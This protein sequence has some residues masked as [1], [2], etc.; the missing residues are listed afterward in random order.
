VLISP[1]CTSGL[2]SRVAEVR[3]GISGWTFP[4]WRGLFYPEGLAQKQELHYASRAL[5]TIEINGTFYSLQKPESFAKWAVDTPD[6]FVFT[7]KAPRFI[8]HIRRL[9]DVGVP[10]AN[11]MASGVLRL[12]HKLGPFLWQLPPNLPFDAARLEAFLSLLPHDTQ[13]AA[14]LAR[15]HDGH[16][17]DA[18]WT[19]ADALRPVRHAIEVRH[20]SF[21]T[22]PFLDLLRAHDIA[23]VCVDTDEWPSLMDLTSDFAYCRLRN[24]AETEPPGYTE[25]QIDRWAERALAWSTGR[26]M[27]DG[28]F[29]DQASQPAARERDVFAYFEHVMKEHA[30]Q[31]AQRLMRRVLDRAGE[32][33]HPATGR[34]AA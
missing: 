10:V 8:T 12:G 11:F 14:A 6:D 15:G 22:K 26:P 32:P 19:E 25:A 29:V 17:K 16:L 30:P 5:R 24:P 20:E 7:V 33:A 34:G 18:A 3:I 21:R 31:N 28:T 1:L 2:G 4:P 23:L 13:A 27:R 9:K